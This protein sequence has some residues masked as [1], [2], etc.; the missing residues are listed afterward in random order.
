MPWYSA[1]GR[2][3]MVGFLAF[4]RLTKLLETWWKGTT[5]SRRSG[6]PVW[7]TL[8]KPR[9][10]TTEKVRTETLTISPKA[11]A[12][13]ANS[14]SLPR[15]RVPNTTSWSRCRS[16]MF[17]ISSR[18]SCLDGNTHLGLQYVLSK[19]SLSIDPMCLKSRESSSSMLG[20]KRKSPVW[21]I[22][23]KEPSN[24]NI[25]APGQ[26]LALITV[27]E[28]E[29]QDLSFVFTVSD[30]SGL[31]SCFMLEEVTWPC[32]CTHLLWQ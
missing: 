7:K 12:T 4:R 17:T 26:W 27:T 22:L 31:D 3:T 6:R 14:C 20:R 11:K 16:A 9:A 21:R 15:A 10:D 30:V 8:G 28:I 5:L 23:P 13:A 24:R 2:M 1:V 25:T 32:A 18:A 19:Y 29:S